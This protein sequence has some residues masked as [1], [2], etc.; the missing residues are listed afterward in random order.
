MQYIKNL[1]EL[2]R[3]DLALAGGK[4]A[5]LGALFQAGLP[6]PGGFCVTTP[7]YL[8]FVEA[9]RLQTQIM[10]LTGDLHAEDPQEL[11]A[12]SAAIRKLFEDCTVPQ[13]IAAEIRAAYAQLSVSTAAAVAVRSSAT[14]EDLP[15]LSF[16]GQQDTYLNVV[17]ET[18][19]VQAV[20]RC[21]ASLWTAR[22]IGYRMRNAIPNEDIALAVVV[23]QMVNSE[24]SG[25]L[26]TA[27][28]LSGKRTQTV[29][30][31]TLGLGEALVSGMVEPDH[32]VVEMGV[33]QKDSTEQIVKR[34]LGA[35]ALSIRGL[36]GGGTQTLSED[37]G[38]LQ[39]LP[40]AQ[41]VELARLGKRSADFFGAPQDMEWAWADGRLFVLQ[42]RAI[43]SLFPLPEGVSA[44]PLEVFFSFAA[45]QGMLEPYSPLGQDV[46][47]SLVVGLGRQFGAV[48]TV[49]GQNIFKEA[50]M[51]L[52][53]N[54]TSLVRNP[55]GR[56]IA[57][58]FIEA[59][60]PVSSSV[61]HEL[62]K[63]PQLAIIPQ[64]MSLKKR[65]RILKGFWP[66]LRNVIFN[67]RRPAK[68]RQRLS[69]AIETIVAQTREKSRKTDNLT[70]LLD[71]MEETALMGPSMLLP[72]LLPGVIAGQIPIQMIIR[73][74]ERDPECKDLPYELTR[75]L[76]H[77]VT[78]EMDLMLWSV[79][80]SIRSD[81][82]SKAV[83][84]QSEATSLAANY[85]AGE[86]PTA[87]QEAVAQFLKLYGMRGVGEIDFYRTR[88]HE[89]PSHVTQM[90]KNYL[91]IDPQSGSPE[92]AFRKGREKA[93]H[94]KEELVAIFKRKH[95]PLRAVLIGFLAERVFELGG[96]R[97]TPKFAIV[98]FLD[99]L[100]QGLLRI[101]QNMA[102]QGVLAQRDDLFFLHLWELRQLADGQLPHVAQLILERRQTYQQEQ[103]R[104][105]IPRILLSDGT[106][107]FDG[108]G[109]AVALGADMLSGA[110]V[111]AGTV[112]GVVHVIMDPH[113]DHLAPGEILVCPATDPAWTPLFLSAGGLVM[114]V[115]G[116]MTHGSVVAR[117]YGIPAVVGVQEATTRLKNGQRIRVDGSSG[118][119]TLLGED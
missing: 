86:L 52:F 72:H 92:T 103:S 73:L 113:K 97:E 51:R 59:I 69:A 74:A 101:G 108:I 78:T 5:N 63:N 18:Q 80:S 98:S 24:A 104:R 8:H 94:A 118:L 85:L 37:S 14:A 25:V 7:A 107:Y 56:K 100:R 105:R 39:A 60:D 47:T 33:Q 12:A 117:E 31:A 43:T 58:M 10:Q 6:V 111:S 57:G 29:I 99:E 66:V 38:A 90:L 89:D 53:V 30:D 4:G 50:S 84:L 83:F 34:T 46:F 77:N 114:E 45:W 71:L 35:K 93:V 40:D 11:D 9:N 91:Q 19:V 119:I 62:Y 26:F 82:P 20:L 115:G 27:N 102:T 61:I 2:N 109:P 3:S 64:K 23:Q 87:A 41:I 22:A 81:A 79:A 49:R 112:E 68:G 70:G 16:A 116:M 32:Y 76:A 44:L 106:T 88:W 55:L 65:F 95:R 28:P 110:P 1:N 36:A 96:L 54:I 67:L 42:S 13:E 48:T 15:T 17:G 21:W 75:G